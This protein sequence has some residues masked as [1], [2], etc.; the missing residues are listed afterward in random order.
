LPINC[1][2]EGVK[3]LRVIAVNF[4]LEHLYT[5]QNDFEEVITVKKTLGET[6]LK[7]SA[8]NAK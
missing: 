2:A 3:V 1:F 4:E 8:F 7:K 5:T 6:D